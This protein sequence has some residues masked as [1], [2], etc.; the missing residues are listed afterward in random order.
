[1]SVSGDPASSVTPQNGQP[2]RPFTIPS[3]FM[4]MD[5][6]REFKEKQKSLLNASKALV[7]PKPVEPVP[8]KPPEPVR[9]DP[10]KPQEPVPQDP[11]QP[12]D[13]AP[14]PTPIPAD[15]VPC[16]PKA[17]PEP[18]QKEVIPPEPEVIPAAPIPAEQEK[19]KDKTPAPAPTP[20]R[21]ESFDYG[22]DLDEVVPPTGSDTKPAADNTAVLGGLDPVAAADKPKAPDQNTAA[23]N[24]RDAGKG[25]GGATGDQ[26][27]DKPLEPSMKESLPA[28]SQLTAPGI[29]A[30][31]A[32]SNP[33]DT[34]AVA[35]SF[36]PDGKQ[37]TVNPS[38]DKIAPPA[39]A[40]KKND[41][42]DDE[43]YGGNEALNNQ[44]PRKR[45]DVGKEL[46]DDSLNKPVAEDQKAN[47]D[48]GP[49]FDD[50][51]LNVTHPANQSLSGAPIKKLNASAGTPDQSIIKH[52]RSATDLDD[53]YSGFGLGGTKDKTPDVG[54]D[55]YQDEDPTPEPPKKPSKAKKP[56]KKKPAPIRED[57]PPRADDD[58]SDNDSLDNQLTNMLQQDIISRPTLTRQKTEEVFSENEEEQGISGLAEESRFRPTNRH[59]PAYSPILPEDEISRFERSRGNLGRKPS[60]SQLSES[61]LYQHPTHQARTSPFSF[62][63][64]HPHNTQHH[65]P[66]ITLNTT[67][68]GRHRTPT[69]SNIVAVGSTL[70]PIAAGC[71]G[72]DN[73]KAYL[74]GLAGS[75]YQVPVSNVG[76]VRSYAS[77]LV[78]AL[79]SKDLK[80]DRVVDVAEAF[81]FLVVCTEKAV[82]A[83]DLQDWGLAFR[84]DF[85][86]TVDTSGFEGYKMVG[87][88][89][90]AGIFKNK[91]PIIVWWAQKSHIILLAPP[92]LEVRSQWQVLGTDFIKVMGKV[93]P[94]IT[95][96]S[97]CY[98]DVN[99][100][101]G[102]LVTAFCDDQQHVFCKNIDI[103]LKALQKIQENLQPYAK[104][105]LGIEG[106]A[107]FNGLSQ[108]RQLMVNRQSRVSEENQFAK[109]AS[110]ISQN[111]LASNSQISD[112]VHLLSL[113]PAQSAAIYG[114]VLTPEGFALLSKYPKLVSF[115]LYTLRAEGAKF[116]NQATMASMRQNRDFLNDHMKKQSNKAVSGNRVF[117]LDHNPTQR[118]TYAY[119]QHKA[120]TDTFMFAQTQQQGGMTED[121]DIPSRLVVSDNSI[122][123]GVRSPAPGQVFMVSGPFFIK[124]EL[125][126]KKS[127]FTKVV[128]R[129][130]G[131]SQGEKSGHFLATASDQVLYSDSQGSVSF[132]RL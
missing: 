50:E 42:D 51:S 16:P 87:C 12:A 90:W 105:N 54:V 60:T 108:Q 19:E 5:A 52:Q 36:S 62:P 128:E 28:Q 93:K 101:K 46:V 119:S 112:T 84:Y 73:N 7:D 130:N 72:R 33:G 103:S 53:E 120:T 86:V 126:N 24:D 38:E 121:P 14:A 30:Q 64:A 71:F 78:C 11:P 20:A 114:L 81:G 17:T 21:D 99:L 123:V 39:N 43:F 15:P 124:A 40:P 91:G 106:S 22:F 89:I 56:I 122:P 96:S 70:D 32:T 9:E 125:S 104:S 83:Y 80:D 57:P 44:I 88:R 98:L 118:T 45:A 127:G 100:E 77:F 102:L 61:R 4:P 47:Q 115:D 3:A 58:F 63:D 74:V 59:D 8:Q 26:S 29:P 41:R 131:Y 37:T 97:R 85:R 76:M 65:G 117:Y 68:T 75:V 92:S 18:S 94:G 25:A 1:M 107:G 34:K 10:P 110:H 79:P 109:I 132:G 55:D 67:T 31:D 113:N 2:S 48:K 13:P 27:T 69:S 23:A 66:N 35:F 95:R 116:Y 6:I 111:T 129:P 49:G 82:F